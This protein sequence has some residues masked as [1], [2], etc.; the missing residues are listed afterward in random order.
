RSSARTTSSV[1]PAGAPD[2][3]GSV[4]RLCPE[5]H[6]QGTFAGSARPESDFQGGAN[7]RRIVQAA[8]LGVAS[9]GPV[10]TARAIPLASSTRR[11]ASSATS[12]SVAFGGQV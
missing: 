9:V 6:L 3:P 8:S 5:S 2:A 10:V 11:G 4:Y 7:L 12:A 1:N